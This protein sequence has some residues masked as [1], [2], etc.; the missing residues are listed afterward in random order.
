MQRW[1][2]LH[3]LRCG[4]LANSVHQGRRK[5]QEPKKASSSSTY[6]SPVAFSKPVLAIFR[7]SP[8]PGT[9][10][11]SFKRQES[12]RNDLT[13]SHGVSPPQT[14]PNFLR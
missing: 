13:W 11:N 2:Q 4:R 5:Q 3:S 6:R 14:H 10:L 12:C 7:N 8:M 9:S 1:L